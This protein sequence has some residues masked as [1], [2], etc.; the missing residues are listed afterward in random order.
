MFKRISEQVL[1]D[2]GDMEGDYRAFHLRD[3]ILQSLLYIAI[4]VVGVFGT[5][6]IDGLMYQDRLDL[7]LRMVLYRGGYILASIMIANAIQKTHKVEVY[8]RLVFAW[9]LITVFFILLCNFTRPAN[10][11]NTAFDVMVPFAI[12]IFL[13]LPI[14]Y[15]VPLAIGFSAGTLC[16]DYFYKTGIDTITWGTLITAQLVAHA[17]GLISGLQIRTYRRRTFKAYMQEKDARERAAY[18]ANIDPLTKGLTRR[19]FF[20]IGESE[21]QRFLR[22]K[23]QLSMLVLDADHFKNIND[24][25]GHY[26]GDLVL[27][28]LSLIILE[29]KRAQD[30]FGRLGGEEFGLLLPETDLEQARAVAERIQ[31]MC[32]QTSC[33]VD[34]KLIHSTFSIGV[35]Q[36]GPVD[37]SFGD[38]LRRADQMMYKAKEAGRNRVVAE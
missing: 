31:K 30:T 3:D 16:I 11:L 29:Q 21:F 12:Y 27:R 10:F 36:A 14:T 17:V 25:H 7:T 28:S 33:P 37:Q 18:M 38:L 22:Y 5:A 15:I 35:A 34:D 2:L 13:P 8:D 19:Q 4:A 32:T 6:W 26:A 23:R 9:V 20:N 24:T 1:T